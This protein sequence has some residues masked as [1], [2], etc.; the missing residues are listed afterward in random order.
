[1]FY[2]YFLFLAMRSFRCILY[3]F[4]ISSIVFYLRLHIL[5]AIALCLNRLVCIV[6]CLFLTENVFFVCAR[7]RVYACVSLV[8]FGMQLN[9]NVVQRVFIMLE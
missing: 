8:E 1:M 5:I 6:G 4:G 9:Y 3:Y 7:A 2:F